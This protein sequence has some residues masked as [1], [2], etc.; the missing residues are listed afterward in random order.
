V[1]DN[2]IHFRRPAEC[3]LCGA[4][5]TVMAE[6][7]VHGDSVFV[8]WCCEKCQGEWPITPD[9]LEAIERRRGLEDRRR[10]TRAERRGGK[11]A[12]RNWS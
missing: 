12:I 9:E 2:L 7:T 6:T 8:A 3:V 1:L 4:V 11:S 5:G 10:T